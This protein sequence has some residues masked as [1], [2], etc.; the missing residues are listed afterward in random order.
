MSWVVTLTNTAFKQLK[1][2]PTKV[3]L[4]NQVL[5]KDLEDK[6][7][8]PGNWPNYGK[9]Y[10]KKN[11]DKRHCHLIKGN[12]TYVSCWEVIDKQKRLIEVYYIG[13]HENAPYSR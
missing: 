12:P 5:V 10:G 9:L 3:A 7:P 2:M 4:V 1:K 11:E 13:T 8:F 6:G